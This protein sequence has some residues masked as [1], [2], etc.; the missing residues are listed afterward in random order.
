M[1]SRLNFATILL[2]VF[3]IH[4]FIDNGLANELNQNEELKKR[5]ELLE[6]HAL[7]I[8]EGFF[9]NGEIEGYY[10]DRRRDSHSGWESRGEF[11]FGVSHDL[12][13]LPIKDLWFGASA[14]YDSDYALDSTKDN[15]LVEK[16]FGFGNDLVRIYAGETDVQR[17]GFAKTPKISVP[18]IYT[19]HNNRIDHHNKTVLAFG[20]FKWDDEFEFDAHRLRK[21]VPF[22]GTIGYDSDQNTTYYNGTVS[23]LGL[24]EVGYMRISS[25]RQVTKYTKST[26]QRGWSIGGSL[27]RFGLPII[28][29]VE[30][31][32]D[33]DEGVQSKKTRKEYG[34]LLSLSEPVYLTF[35]RTENDDLGYSGNYYGVIYT[36]HTTSDEHKRP[37]QRDGIEFGIYLHDKEQT[38]VY[39]GV[40]KD[41][42][43]QF[44]ADVKVRF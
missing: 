4:I 42:G 9:I 30:T 15:T 11:Q 26:N 34:G 27:Y 5:V 18:L 13:E 44:L 33:R 12:K 14:T 38:S 39:T 40:Y 24:F 28:W 6:K 1:V 29:G 20:G 32:D 8:P 36:Y 19:K 22:G 10:N 7:K 35:H 23:V 2:V 17:L 41:H 43:K 21:N 25:P 37:D 3:I 31:W 16:Q